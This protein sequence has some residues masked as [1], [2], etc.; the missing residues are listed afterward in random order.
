MDKGAVAVSQYRLRFATRRCAET[1]GLVAA[2]RHS[3]P[4]FDSSRAPK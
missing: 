3:L 4:D 1:A 2:G